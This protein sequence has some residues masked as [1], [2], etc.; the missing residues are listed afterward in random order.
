MAN[1][2]QENSAE[3]TRQE[4]REK[5]LRKKRQKMKQHGKGLA[6]IYE[7]AARKRTGERSEGH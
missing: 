1:E 2:P 7:D 6:K 4:T 5:K 3:D